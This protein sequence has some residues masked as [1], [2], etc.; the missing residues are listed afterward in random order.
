MVN[1]NHIVIPASNRDGIRTGRNFIS[2]TLL[3]DVA[4]EGNETVELMI[5]S[6]DAERIRV[7]N[8]RRPTVLTITDDDR[9]LEP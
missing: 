7:Q 3:D 4:V 5:E 1:D 6:V 8:S 9:K 2:M